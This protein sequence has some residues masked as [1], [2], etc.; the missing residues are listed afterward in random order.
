MTTFTN[1]KDLYINNLQVQPTDTNSNISQIDKEKKP[2]DKAIRKAKSKNK[3]K[4]SKYARAVRLGL[5]LKCFYEGTDNLEFRR[6]R[7]PMDGFCRQCA[8][9]MASGQERIEKQRQLKADKLRKSH[10]P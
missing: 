10:G 7:N 9:K 3:K 2:K 4:E 5:C 1:A 6:P 8:V